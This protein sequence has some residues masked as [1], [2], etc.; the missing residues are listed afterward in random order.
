MPESACR[1]PITIGLQ[2]WLLPIF[3]SCGEHWVAG[4]RYRFVAFLGLWNVVGSWQK[5]LIS[6]ELRVSFAGGHS[7]RSVRLS[8]VSLEGCDPATLMRLTSLPVV[9]GLLDWM[10]L[11]DRCIRPQLLE[12]CEWCGE[13]GCRDHSL[14]LDMVSCE[15]GFCQ[16][17]SSFEGLEYLGSLLDDRIS[18]CYCFLNFFFCL[19]LHCCVVVDLSKIC[20]GD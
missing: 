4:Q 12:K 10:A 2:L 19:L 9:G 3:L 17:R 16:E 7:L 18:I 8:G 15:N 6:E 1:L 11:C 5:F 14:E 20:C 13:R